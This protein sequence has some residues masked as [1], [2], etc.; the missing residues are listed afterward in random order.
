ME[1]PYREVIESR[2]KVWKRGV[3]FKVWGL[4]SLK[5]GKTNS[6]ADLLSM[7]AVCTL[8]ENAS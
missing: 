3:I 5:W 4:L 1:T 7:G 8:F 6:G 2:H